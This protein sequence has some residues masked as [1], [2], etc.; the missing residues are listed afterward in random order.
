MT[1]DFRLFAQSHGLVINEI[2][3]DGKIH[4]VK[5]TDKPK[6][7]NGRY[8]F[9]PVTQRG[10]V[11]DWAKHSG[12]VHFKSDKP[13]PRLTEQDLQASKQ[14]A[15]EA[16]KADRDRQV[17]CAKVAQDVVKGCELDYHSYLNQKGFAPAMRRM[18]A[19][20]GYKGLVDRQ[21]ALLRKAAQTVSQTLLGP[22][23]ANAQDL[24]VVPVRNASRY[25]FI[26][27]VQWISPDGDKLFLKGARMADGVLI[28][29]DRKN[30]IVWFCEGYAT[31]LTLLEAARWANQLAQIHVCFSAGS[32]AK[33]V[34][35]VK[36]EHRFIFADH[37]KI[38]SLGERTGERV[39]LSSGLPWCCSPVEGEDANDLMARDGIW[40]VVQ[41]MTQVQHA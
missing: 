12:P 34:T 40:S 24:L 27:S 23:K 31:G 32:L 25:N 29:G 16:A 36:A 7:R 14:R 35:R 11:Q 1:Q 4:H 37:D 8:L 2:I 21:G 39:A 5:T 17:F 33:Q 9:D 38:N 22:W 26:Q 10:W 30:P 6:R 20:G 28:L 13:I 19:S 18:R 15:R 41:Q 3:D